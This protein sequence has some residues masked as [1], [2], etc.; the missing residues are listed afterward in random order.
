MVGKMVFWKRILTGLLIGGGSGWLVSPHSHQLEASLPSEGSSI[1]RKR[2]PTLV[3]T[4]NCLAESFLSKGPFFFSG[5]H[6]RLASVVTNGEVSAM[7]NKHRYSVIIDSREDRCFTVLVSR[8]HIRTKLLG[9][10]HRSQ[11]YGWDS[12]VPFRIAKTAR[13][14]VFAT[15]SG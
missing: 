1:P 5:L 11:C 4:L 13:T 6:H 15:R 2:P 10:Y 8:I 9:V 14:N 3:R 12:E 7:L